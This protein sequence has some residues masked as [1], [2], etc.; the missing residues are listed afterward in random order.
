MIHDNL[1]QTDFFYN[2]ADESKWAEELAPGT[3][4]EESGNPNEA[5]EDPTSQTDCRR[6]VDFEGINR[7]DQI[8]PPGKSDRGKDKKKGDPDHIGPKKRWAVLSH[9]SCRIAVVS[10]HAE[11]D[12]LKRACLAPPGAD[13][14]I[15]E[16]DQQKENRH[17]DH[18]GR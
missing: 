13:E 7:I 15:H 3:I 10:I 16:K 5:Q 6:L 8:S 1:E 17:G 11:D 12:V 9:D 18:P 2:P 14:F 4:N